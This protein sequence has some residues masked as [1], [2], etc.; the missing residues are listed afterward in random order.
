MTIASLS[1]DTVTHRRVARAAPPALVVAPHPR[2]VAAVALAPAPR[3]RLAAAA[4][5]PPAPSAATGTAAGWVQIGA[6]SSPDLADQGWRDI[7]RSAPD[8]MAGKG[9][10]VQPFDRDGKTL[11]RTY[12]TG[13]SGV[14]AAQAFCDDLRA[15]GKAC[16]VK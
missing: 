8:A 12:V 6:F 2:A 11:Y 15:A 14:S 5:P 4:A 7:A 1:D 16:M 10:A 3:P 13:F 9:K